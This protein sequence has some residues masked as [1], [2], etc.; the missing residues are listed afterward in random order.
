MQFPNEPQKG[1]AIPLVIFNNKQYKVSQEAKDLLSSIEYQQIAIVSVV[2]KYRT[3][4]SFL[5]N[6]ILLQEKSGFKIGSTQKACTKGVWIYS[7]PKVLTY[8]NKPLHCFFIDTEGLGAYDE[9]VNHDTKI[10]LVAILISSLFIYNS[11]GTIDEN[12][13]NTLSFIINLSKYLKISSE[14]KENPENNSKI[15][16]Y[17]PSF[18][19]LLRDFSL[20]LVDK[21]NNPITINDYLENVLNQEGNEEKS[22]VRRAIKESF[23]KRDAFGLVRPM[24]N[25]KDLQNLENLDDTK[26]RKEFQSQCKELRDMVFES[27]FPK[28]LNGRILTGENLINF[29]IDIVQSVNSGSIPVIENSWKYM[30]ETENIS[31]LKRM[32]RTFIDLFTRYYLK[33]IESIGLSPF[34]L[35][36]STCN[37]SS[38]S[39]IFSYNQPGDEEKEDSQTDTNQ[40]KS[41]SNNRQ[42]RLNLKDFNT[43]LTKYKSVLISDLLTEYTKNNPYIFP[44]KNSKDYIEYEEKLNKLCEAE[45]KKFYETELEG[46]Y[47]KYLTTLIEEKSLEINTYINTY[48]TQSKDLPSNPSISV[49]FYKIL[50]EIEAL[51]DEI[52]LNL[53]YFPSKSSISTQKIFSLIKKTHEET[54]IKEKKQ[55]EQVI[56]MLNSEVLTMKHSINKKDD[57]INSMSIEFNERLESIQSQFLVIKH[58]NSLLKSKIEVYDKEKKDLTMNFNMKIIN[59]DKENIELQRKF[60]IE[61][62]RL[63]DESERKDK[64]MLIFKLNHEKQIILNESKV[65]LVIKENNDIK[66]RILE[67]IKEKEEIELENNEKR[68]EI[69]TLKDRIQSMEREKDKEKEKEKDKPKYNNSL[70]NI[71]NK[72]TSTQV[73]MNKLIKS[74]ENLKQQLENTKKIYDDIIKNLKTSLEE[75][76]YQSQKE[77]NSKILVEN[78]KNL[79]VVIKKNEDKCLKLEEKLRKYSIFKRIIKA[80]STFQCGECYKH[81]SFD[82][83][84]RH[85]DF[86]KER[87]SFSVDKS[88]K[89][90]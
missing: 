55:Y 85:V 40:S 58:E 75:K 48:T 12:S 35:Q 22:K 10:F 37:L 76:N 9:E 39:S 41:Y 90:K 89:I 64:Q 80:S 84:S 45:Y 51:S 81:F 62:Q 25:E 27:I 52:E 67:M 16:E 20:K 26:L 24:E 60:S 33:E 13:I 83:F 69:D 88:S 87:S 31:N 23:K 54:V 73:E 82:V 57:E 29:L 72:S 18:L 4:K 43:Q 1:T 86:C 8:N 63:L 59:L 7:K 77:K 42:V 53:P 17:L 15:N 2:G 44:N 34:K 14:N 6:R 5:L 68:C 78:N 46:L 71:F 11:T 32:G 28:S 3:G 30:L 56:S 19:W 38:N 50:L 61:R 47:I 36:G 74:N 21:E 79:S 66:Q 49:G 70:S 65:D